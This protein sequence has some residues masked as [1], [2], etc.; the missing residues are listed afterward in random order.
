MLAVLFMRAQILWDELALNYT[1]TSSVERILA[2]CMDDSLHTR[3]ELLGNYRLAGRIAFW[4]NDYSSAVHYLN[5]AL[6]QENDRFDRYLLGISYYWLG[7]TQTA[8]A[9][10]FLTLP[11]PMARYLVHQAVR[12]NYLGDFTSAASHTEVALR[13][14]PKLGEAYLE[15]GRAQAAQDEWEM[16]LVNYEKAARLITDRYKLSS[17]YRSMATLDSRMGNKESAV[18]V[19][20][21]ALTIAPDVYLGYLQLASAYLDMGRTD[22]AIATLE[23]AILLEPRNVQAYLRMGDLYRDRDLL[24]DALRWYQQA[25]QIDPDSGRAD[26]AIGALLL[27]NSQPDESIRHLERAVASGWQ[28]YWVLFDL[29]GAYEQMGQYKDAAAVYKQV[30]ETTDIPET[31]LLSA[32]LK[33]AELYTKTGEEDQAN[34]AWLHVLILEPQHPTIPQFIRDGQ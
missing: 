26:Y 9:Q 27:R 28:P 23:T 8:L 2:C 18:E 17:L 19:L 12:A 3:L 4:E 20:E 25:K 31:T 32:W 6:E 11:Q 33:L 15:L 29:G 7:E 30:T 34:E 21:K 24:E 13:L 14:D 1:H 10:W 22:D 5:L 16:A